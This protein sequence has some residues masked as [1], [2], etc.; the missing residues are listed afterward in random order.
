M[1]T[2]YPAD[3][4][5]DGLLDYI[6]F[7]NG[8]V[9]LYLTQTDG[10]LAEKKTIFTNEAMQNAF[11]VILIKMVMLIFCCSFLHQMQPILYFSE[12]TGTGC[13]RKKRAIS[14]ENIQVLSAKIMMQM[15]CMKFLLATRMPKRLSAE[16]Q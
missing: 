5:G 3:F 16:M 4:N 12:M 11:L 1:G 10:K 2:I 7:G 8:N 6:D 13:L 15:V 9:D 14:M